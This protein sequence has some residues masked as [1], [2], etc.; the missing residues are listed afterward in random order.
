MPSK[1]FSR[2]LS[3]IAPHLNWPRQ[4]DPAHG[5]HSKRPKSCK[6]ELMDEAVAKRLRKNAKRLAE[7]R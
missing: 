6:A 7:V 1:S 4:P 3:M 2:L 5:P